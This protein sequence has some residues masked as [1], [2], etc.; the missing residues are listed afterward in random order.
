V[1]LIPGTSRS[2]IVITG[3]RFLGFGR[4]DAARLSMLMSIPTLAASGVLIGAE[5]IATGNGA[6]LRDAAIAAGFAFLAGLAA[7][8]VMMRLL[9]TV[10][11]T[12]YVV[13]RM[14]L[15]VLLLGIAYG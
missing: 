15:G 11:F 1:A 12:P 13:Y 2:G 9:R 5:L 4:S 10:S 7:L 6:A 3:A 14:A 8:T